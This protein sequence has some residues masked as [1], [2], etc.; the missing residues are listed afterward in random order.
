MRDLPPDVAHV[1]KAKALSVSL[2]QLRLFVTLARHRSFTRAGDEFGITQSAVSRSIRELEDEIELRLFDRTTRQVA[3]TDIGRHLLAAHRAARGRTR[4]D[5]AAAFRRWLRAG[6]RQAREQFE[7]DRE[8]AAR[9]A[10]ILPGELSRTVDRARRSATERRAPTRALGRGGPGRRRRAR[11]P[12]RT[13]RRAALR[14]SALCAR[15]GAPSACS[16]TE[17]ELA[18]RCAAQ[19][20]PHPRRRYRQ[21]T[22]PSIARSCC[23]TWR[24]RCGNRLRRRPPSRRWSR[25]GSASASCRCMRAAAAQGGARRRSR[26]RRKSRGPSCSCAGRAARCA[27]AR[28]T[29]GRISSPRR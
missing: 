3:L 29:C 12:R 2:H 27:R 19:S 14:R 21:L 5:L 17:R 20:A 28:R 11:K 22:R 6:H 18:R 26:S 13:R 4:S 24:A 7:P 10:R 15:A 23:M 9:V 25:R 16:A 8:R 1:P